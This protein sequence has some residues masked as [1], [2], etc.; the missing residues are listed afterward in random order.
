M[1]YASTTSRMRF[2]GRLSPKPTVPRR[3]SRQLPFVIDTV[4]TGVDLEPGKLTD[5][6]AAA[7]MPPHG[8][9]ACRALRQS[10]LEL[11]VNA[12]AEMEMSSVNAYLA[13][14]RR[15]LPALAFE[16]ARLLESSGQFNSVVCLDDKWIFRFPKSS[17]AAA[18]LE[19]ELKLLPR[20]AGL[21]PL[22][23]PTPGFSARAP[24]TGR[25]LYMGYAK[26]R[27]EPLLRHRYAALKH[28]E[29]AI[30]QLASDLAAF[31]LALHQIPPASLGLAAANESARDEW[32]RIYGEIQQR[33]Y[34][35]M[36][37]DARRAVT[38][39]FETALGERDLWRQQAC[40]IHGDFG[41]GNILIADGRISGIIDFGFCG[42]GDPAQ[43]LGAL[44]ASY[45][46]DFLTRLL[47]YYP[48]LGE[49]R[50]RAR[51]YAR[52]YALIQALYAL[53]DGDAAEFEAGIAAYR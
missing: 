50:G 18:D 29:A 21:L 26:L 39:D 25:V 27:G 46:A 34:P 33:L 48:A 20:L 49:H 38:R 4:A 15:H 9:A 19:N 53:R 30:E 12:D 35:Y 14:L 42:V 11:I 43:D 31:L 5:G 16:R 2:A 36:R 3:H 52:N 6:A 7:T 1:P 13:L 10:Y 47:T 8:Q 28:D 40:L 44:L 24:V 32:R 41:T 37:A 45:G 23:I 51:F 17:Q 22:P